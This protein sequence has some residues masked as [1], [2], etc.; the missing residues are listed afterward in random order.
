MQNPQAAPPSTG[1]KQTIENDM[2]AVKLPRTTIDK[3]VTDCF[4]G[5]KPPSE[6]RL[7]EYIPR[8]ETRLF[9]FN[10]AR[11]A[12]IKRL[13]QLE[14]QNQKDEA[15]KLSQSSTQ[16]QPQPTL[17]V[18]STAQEIPTTT[19]E[20]PSTT[21]T[22]S[23]IPTSSTASENP[24]SS[25][26]P[27]KTENQ[28]TNSTNPVINQNTPIQPITEGISSLSVATPVSTTSENSNS[29]TVPIQPVNSL[30]LP[31]AGNQPPYSV[32]PVHPV[33]ATQ[34]TSESMQQTQ[35]QQ[36]PEQNEFNNLFIDDIDEDDQVDQDLLRLM[37]NEE[38][39]RTG[40]LCDVLSEIV[41][42]KIIPAKQALKEGLMTIMNK[43]IFRNP[44]SPL[45]NRSHMRVLRALS[46]YGEFDDISQLVKGDGTEMIQKDGIFELTLKMLKPLTRE[47]G[48]KLI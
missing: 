20:A 6:I 41:K 36:I 28:V 46:H 18:P 29:L 27:I 30:L 9:R 8:L 39:L 10:L 34:S 35:P 2:D 1:P 44:M 22:T 13:E 17:Q 25:P 7:S 24:T 4:Q 23:I 45:I 12:E 42:D 16:V 5:N 43:L 15:A 14:L 37:T 38:Y 21:S 3:I 40:A 26:A 33:S 47:I 19:P 32:T 11:R 48:I 31:P